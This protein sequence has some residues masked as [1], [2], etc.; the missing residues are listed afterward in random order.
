MSIDPKEASSVKRIAGNIMSGY[1]FD[2]EHDGLDLPEVHAI[3]KAV[4]IAEA[5]N[6]EV[7]SRVASSERKEPR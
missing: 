4:N 7:N 2:W 6:D 5:I 3:H 1:S